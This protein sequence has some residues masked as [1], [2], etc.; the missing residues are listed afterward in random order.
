MSASTA[1]LVMSLMADGPG[2]T[3]P[4]QIDLLIDELDSPTIPPAGMAIPTIWC[5]VTNALPLEVAVS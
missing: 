2:V 4:L 5:K 3:R 1:E